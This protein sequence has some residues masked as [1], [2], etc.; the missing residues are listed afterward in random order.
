MDKNQLV[1]LLAQVS[2]PEKGED[3]VSLGMLK[4][5]D[6]QEDKVIVVLTS[7]KAR[8]PFAESIMRACQSVIETAF[9]G[10]S[11]TVEMEVRPVE[12]RK[13]KETPKTALEHVK[14][15]VAVASGKGGVGKSSVAVNLAVSLA[16]QGVKVGLLDADIYGPSV[17]KMLG[18]EGAVPELL[19][20]EDKQ[21]LIPVEKY[22]V[23]VLSIGF[24]VKPE[25]PLVWRGPM[26]TS[27]LKQLLLQAAWG[28]L[29]VLVLDMPPGTGDVHLTITQEIR[30]S[31]AVIVSTPQEVALADV[32]KGI[33][34]FQSE[35]INV[36]VLGLVENMAW[37]TPA[38]L[39]DHQYYIFGKE[40]VL[41]LSQKMN[42][43]LLAQ[44][45]LVQ[46]VCEGGDAGVPAVLQ[47]DISAAA[48]GILAAKVMQALGK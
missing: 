5:I 14:Y 39:P 35:K 41:R 28:E 46:A 45:P 13:V 17:P 6:I 15:I 7:G 16:Q 11:L 38:E 36:P 9:P 32:V 37:F 34:M 27:A 29:D 25:D 26:A 43:P 33:N 12:A 19:E 40:G 24:F 8:D 31:G 18:L 22:G 3:I 48:F 20:E 4:R 21:W 2:H 23:K 42:M 1:A 44:L 10:I 47:N 30:L